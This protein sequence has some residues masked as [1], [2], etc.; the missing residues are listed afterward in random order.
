MLIARIREGIVE[1]KEYQITRSGRR[2]DSGGQGV[3]WQCS[4]GGRSGRRLC[5]HLAMLFADAR[6]SQNLGRNVMRAEIWLMAAGHKI[7][8]IPF[9]TAPKG[10]D[11]SLLAK[12]V[13]FDD[14]RAEQGEAYAVRLGGR[15]RKYRCS[16]PHYVHR[17][18]RTGAHCKH[19]KALKRAAEQGSWNGIE[20]A[21]NYNLT[22]VGRK[23][24]GL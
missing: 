14:D 12:V 11:T 19:I 15:G 20:N 17:L 1:G 18:S 2:K 8:Q 13:S 24:F 6:E 21:A 7:L 9:R 4:C 22:D 10:P 16:C 23:H 3:A 5:V